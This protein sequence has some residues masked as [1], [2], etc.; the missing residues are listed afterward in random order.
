MAREI[1]EVVRAA[2]GLAATVLDEARKLPTTLP[3]L[4]VRLIGQAL[5]TS[6]HLQ[7]QYSG[8]VARGDEVLTSLRGDAEPGMATFDDD[9]VDE[10][11]LPARP[12][13]A[14]RS[15]AF[16]RVVDLDDDLGDDLATE[17]PAEEVADALAD[18]LA[19]A[20]LPLADPEDLSEEVAAVLAVSSDDTVAD[21]TPAEVA[22]L[23]DDPAADAV[24]AVVD[25][26]AAEVA[27]EV[28]AEVPDAVP[29]EVLEDLTADTVADVAEEEVEIEEAVADELVA[30]PAVPGT[31]PAEVLAGGVSTLEDV[32][33]EQVPG[34]TQIVDDAVPDVPAL[35]DAAE[36]LVDLG[37]PEAAE[38]VTP[39]S[40]V[41]DSAASDPL[42]PSDETDPAGDGAP[43]SPVEGYE[44]FSIP[45]LRGHLRAYPT[46]TVA[47]LLDYERATRARAPYVTLLQNRLEKL[48]ADRG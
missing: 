31:P 15:S 8:L 47:D 33:P 7:Q 3:G 14:G 35:D 19:A 45:A 2:A 24:T 28:A 25:E 6:L 12:A 27:D 46:E 9:D 38:S 39:G 21:L 10:A 5:Q 41:T 29:A 17:P 22:A 44:S 36:E 23:P 34:Q 48:S 30:E 43:V 1:P 20:D 18:D 42:V 11:P 37:G 13:S 4:P 40:D 26:L 16:D 32:A